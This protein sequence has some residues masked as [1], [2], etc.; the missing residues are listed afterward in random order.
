MN[1]IAVLPQHHIVIPNSVFANGI[2]KFIMQTKRL[3]SWMDLTLHWLALLCLIRLIVKFS[4]KWLL[5]LHEQQE[6]NHSKLNK[7]QANS[8]LANRTNKFIYRSMNC[9]QK[10]SELN[11]SSTPSVGFVVSNQVHCKNWRE[12]VIKSPWTTWAKH[13]TLPWPMEQIN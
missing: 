8:A 9:K 5:S 2:H 3:R 7:W 11:V 6:S 13:Q 1:N 10:D 12:V 4:L